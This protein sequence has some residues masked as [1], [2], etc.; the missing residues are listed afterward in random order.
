MALS[1]ILKI[2]FGICLNTIVKKPLLV[3]PIGFGYFLY[4]YAYVPY[5]ILHE[6]VQYAHS[7]SCTYSPAI[8]P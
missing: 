6:K 1:T 5:P 8:R 2:A 7:C 4:H 3:A